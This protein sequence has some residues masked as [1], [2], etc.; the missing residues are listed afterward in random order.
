MRTIP[1]T[2]MA[3]AAGI[4]PASAKDLPTF[5]VGVLSIRPA[6]Q[7]RRSGFYQGPRE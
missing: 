4:L 1:L 3:I 5:Q 2:I 6:R 7:H